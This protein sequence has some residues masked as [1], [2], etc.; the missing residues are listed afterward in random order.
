MALLPGLLQ[1]LGSWLLAWEPHGAAAGQFLACALQHLG[2]VCR[3]AS[4]T[5]LGASI[6]PG[7]QRCQNQCCK[8]ATAPVHSWAT[9][10]ITSLRAKSCICTLLPPVWRL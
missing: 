2:R 4:Q 6:R 7:S 8:Q 5:D 9:Q 1:A 10:V 3:W